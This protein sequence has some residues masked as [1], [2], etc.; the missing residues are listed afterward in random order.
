MR[1]GNLPSQKGPICVNSFEVVAAENVHIWTSF[2][3]SA[4]YGIGSRFSADLKA[5][6][7]LISPGPEIASPLVRPGELPD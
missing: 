3:G 2:R 1:I 7:P 5:R 6:K 4:L